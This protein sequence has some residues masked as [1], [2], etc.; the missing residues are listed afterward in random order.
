[1]LIRKISDRILIIWA[2]TILAFTVASGF[3]W[4][5]VLVGYVVAT[6]FCIICHKELDSYRVKKPVRNFFGRVFGH[7]TTQDS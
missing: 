1:M 4:I 2:S 6:G 3:N 7:G 5:G